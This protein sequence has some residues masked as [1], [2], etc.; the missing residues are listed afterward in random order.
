MKQ[1]LAFVLVLFVVAIGFLLLNDGL[2]R[3]LVFSS[4]NA[5]MYRMYRLFNASD[6]DL[7][8]LGSSRAEANFAPSEIGSKAF[9]Y[10]LSGSPQGETII[11]LKALL[12]RGH[13]GPII[14]NLDPWGIGGLEPVQGDYRLVFSDLL[15]EANTI[16][17]LDWTDRSAGLRF[18]G[19]LRTALADYINAKRSV[20][21]A[22]DNG[23]ILQRVSRSADEWKYIIEHC[24]PVD[25]T[26]NDVV[27]ADYEKVLK[28]PHP[29]IIFVVSPISK[30]WYDRWHGQD[31]LT[32]LIAKLKTFPNTC[33]IDLCTHNVDSYD[34][35]DF[36]DLT[37]LNEKGARR[38]SKELKQKLIDLGVSRK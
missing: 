8:I 13:Q 34:L 28:G 37:H 5:N 25:F 7:P 10:G 2:V 12:Q 21:K 9:N 35:D 19:K 22:I 31:Q 6:D 23:A 36:M 30:P 38:V 26:V 27:M 24:H 20:T 29:P 33:V 16:K 11:H 3:V 17:G 4:S 15:R 32:K 14:V 18:Y 1:F